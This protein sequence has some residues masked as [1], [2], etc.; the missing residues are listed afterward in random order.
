MSRNRKRGKVLPILI[1]DDPPILYR[2]ARDQALADENESNKAPAS[3]EGEFSRLASGGGSV[4]AE[5]VQDESLPD[6]GFRRTVNPQPESME[7]R[8]PGE[9]E[10]ALDRPR[11]QPHHLEIQVGTVKEQVQETPQN[12]DVEDSYVA[13]AAFARWLRQEGAQEAYVTL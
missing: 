10:M 8:L 3:I 2:S 1:V 5:E 9:T 6:S 12:L 7:R 4:L 11:Q 13:A